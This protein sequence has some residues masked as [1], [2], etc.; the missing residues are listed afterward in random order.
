MSFSGSG[1][2]YH[3]AEQA[4]EGTENKGSLF[5]PDGK[6]EIEM[7]TLPSAYYTGLGSVY[8]PP[9]L[10]VEA[11]RKDNGEKFKTHAFLSEGIPNRWIAGS[12]PQSRVAPATGEIGRAMFYN[13]RENLPL[14]QN[15]E[16]L[17]RAKGYP[18]KESE[19]ASASH[20]FHVSPWEDIPS[21]A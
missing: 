3:N 1:L 5:S 12:P 21:P 4:F 9:V 10:I 16:M 18:S 15:Q 14:S 17:C 6:F 11:T 7:A 19:Y 8:V 13:G 20:F 2:P